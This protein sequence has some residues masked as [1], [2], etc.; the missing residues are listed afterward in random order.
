M[1]NVP[2]FL[3]RIHLSHM[4]FNCAYIVLEKRKVIL[5]VYKKDEERMRR[6][7]THIKVDHPLDE[8]DK[9]SGKIL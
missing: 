2:T 8:F 3:L 7:H 5:F 4:I 9:T 1:L 6:F